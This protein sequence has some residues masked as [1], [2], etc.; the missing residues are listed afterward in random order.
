MPEG[1]RTT[2][3][4]PASAGASLCATVLSGELNG[5]IAHTTPRGTRIVNPMRSFRPGAA[6][7]GTSSPS[8]RLASSADSRSVSTQRR[9]SLSPSAAVNPASAV[10]SRSSIALRDATMSAAFVRI[11][12]RSDASRRCARNPASAPATASSTCAADATP[13]SAYGWSR[14]FSRST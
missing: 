3:L 9:T 4:P 8:S 12:A 10:I 2:A 13:T 6:D 14:N 1:L 5:V 7:I 11:A